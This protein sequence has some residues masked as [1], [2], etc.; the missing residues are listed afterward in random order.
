MTTKRDDD[1]KAREA[2]ETPTEGNV[3]QG[4]RRRRG[5][6]ITAKD[7]GWISPTA[8]VAPITLVPIDPPRPIKKSPPVG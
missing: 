4:E 7:A 5:R 8:F 6:V 2:A 1:D 3:P